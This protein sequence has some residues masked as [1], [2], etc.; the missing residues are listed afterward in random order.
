M[1]LLIIS[2]DNYA[3]ENNNGV[4]KI[5]TNLVRFCESQNIKYDFMYCG[6]EEVDSVKY[7]RGVKIQQKKFLRGVFSTKPKSVNFTESSWRELSTLIEGYTKEYDIYHFVGVGFGGVFKY[8]PE[9]ILCKSVWT[10]IDSLSLHYKTRF[11]SETKT[12]IK[13]YYYYEFVRSLKYENYSLKNS[14]KI[15]AVT[16]VSNVDV[17]WL[18]ETASFANV[19]TIPNGVNLD[20]FKSDAARK[21]TRINK[22]I[23]TGNMNYAPNNM[24]AHLL[25]DILAGTNYNLTIAGANPSVQLVNKTCAKVKVLGYV[26]SM[27]DELRKADIYVSLLMTGSGIKNKIL[28]AMA[29]GMCVIGTKISFDGI[30]VTP[31][32]NCIVLNDC[33]DLLSVLNNLKIEEVNNIGYKA[34]ELMEGKYSWNNVGGKYLSAYKAVS[35]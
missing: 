29:I 9:N 32:S 25:C 3:N 2:D 12:M 28:E 11:K 5:L 33:A 18:R 24:A 31:G 35:I 8:L 19:I 4:S 21:L 23:F 1:K 26:P 14:K 20:Y 22:I 34:R 13:G 10:M 27:A 30:D 15:K 16:L 17:E 7:I 6:L